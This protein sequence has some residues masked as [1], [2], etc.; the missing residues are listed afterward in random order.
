MKAPLPA[1]ETERLHALH[2]LGLLDTEPEQAFDDLTR[3]AS[4]ICGTPMAMVSLIDQDRQWFKSRVGLETAETS[5][6]VAFCAHAILG[7]DMLLV[8][9]ATQDERFRDNPLVTGEQAAFRF[10]AGVPLTTSDGLAVG[11][12]CTIDLT[13]RVL[14]TEQEEALRI[15]ARQAAT[16]FHL[17]ES[18]A[19]LRELEAMRDS[20]TQ[21]IVH[22]LRTPLTSLLG[23]LDTLPALGE[24]NADQ[25][26]FVNLAGDGG[27]T[28]LGLIND[29]LD[30]SKME[31]GTM[32]LERKELDVEGVASA[33]VR[34][35]HG[36]VLERDIHL[37][38]SIARDLPV[39]S[40]DADKIQRVL[41]NLLGNA[42][43]FTP[44]G[45]HISLFVVEDDGGGLRFGVQDTGEGIP[46][47]DLERIFEKFG[48]VES[49][50][51]G[52]KMSTGLGLTFCKMAVE[53]H[54][55]RIWAESEP[56]SGSLFQFTLPPEAP[57]AP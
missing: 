42:A 46:A 37:D 33:A 36:M 14:T 40:A 55:G 38:I 47:A 24:L 43:K 22:D 15:L 5:R 49:R 12:L 41:V 30:V 9:D 31:S 52:R 53:A 50:K 32:P 13:P 11:T 20:L 6:D 56:G 19:R 23:G 1:R 25:M 10:Y 21:M 34:Q 7:D 51:A 2:R 16:H 45:G 3:L 26:E 4:L 18:Y 27:R 54:N 17:R 48:Q 28:L 39:V 57:T 35:V 44:D 29:M 8:P